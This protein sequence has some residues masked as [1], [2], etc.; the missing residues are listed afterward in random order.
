MDSADR[1]AAELLY[2]I[3][4]LSEREK[5]VRRD[6]AWDTLSNM[7]ARLIWESLEPGAAAF[8]VVY[9]LMHE[10]RSNLPKIYRAIAWRIC[11]AQPERFGLVTYREQLWSVLASV[12]YWPEDLEGLSEGRLAGFI[13]DE[14]SARSKTDW[15][16]R[17]T[18]DIQRDAQWIAN[19]LL[20]DGKL[21]TGMRTLQRLQLAKQSALTAGNIILQIPRKLETLADT[22]V[23]QAKEGELPTH[24]DLL[25]RIASL[26]AKYSGSTNLGISSNASVPFDLIT[27]DEDQ[28][29][30]IIAMTR[31]K[32][33]RAEQEDL[34]RRMVYLRFFAHYAFGERKPEDIEVVA[35]FYADKDE[36]HDK[37]FGQKPMFNSEELWSFETFWDYVAGRKGGAEIVERVTT[38]AAAGLKDK[39]VVAKLRLFVSTERKPAGQLF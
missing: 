10:A 3:E 37:W 26:A 7:P 14:L 6:A 17:R 30:R 32:A 28:R 8:F 25:G 11:S 16:S 39:D 13:R 36:S 2:R 12:D 4:N 24:G 33:S 21:L 34:R 9:K 5:L 19:R 38:K 20:K 31:H 18:E 23:S 15:L 35:A 27:L 22:F 29:L 1:L